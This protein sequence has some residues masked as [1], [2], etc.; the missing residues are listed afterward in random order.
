MIDPHLSST[1][2]GE[3]LRMAETVQRGVSAEHS[4]FAV[5]SQSELLERVLK[6]WTAPKGPDPIDPREVA[7]EKAVMN[8]VRAALVTHYL[9]STEDEVR[10]RIFVKLVAR[11]AH[12]M[13]FTWL[14]HAL[15]VGEE[16]LETITRTAANYLGIAADELLVIEQGFDLEGA[17]LNYHVW[18]EPKPAPPGAENSKWFATRPLHELGVLVAAFVRDGRPSIPFTETAAWKHA[19]ELE[20]R[21][22]GLP[23]G[24][25]SSVVAW[26]VPAKSAEP[27]A[28]PISLDAVCERC[29]K[30]PAYV[31]ARF[32]G[33]ACSAKHEAG[34]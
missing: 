8:V 23:A 4:A 9:R 12:L 26:P 25:L 5:Q 33:A 17:D 27:A 19:T 20:E 10:R 30:T 28:S 22:M 15:C 3:L 14:A 11:P 29:G 16:K 21:R 2:I 34:R 13:D 31:G 1:S 32:C 7:F 6:R 18:S 24:A